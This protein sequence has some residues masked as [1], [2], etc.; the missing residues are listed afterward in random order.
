MVSFEIHVLLCVQCCSAR[1][2]W[3]PRYL[4]FK[5]ASL[6]VLYIQYVR[7]L[8]MKCIRLKTI[9]MHIYFSQPFIL[10]NE[11]SLYKLS[12]LE[13]DNPESCRVTWR[14]FLRAHLRARLSAAARPGLR[15]LPWLALLRPW[16]SLHKSLTGWLVRPTLPLTYY[17]FPLHNSASPLRPV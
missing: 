7:L 1:K 10:N 2:C 16:T 11:K 8:Y 12:V 14:G 5:Y 3:V 17:T 4:W 9:H 6:H 13:K 15:P